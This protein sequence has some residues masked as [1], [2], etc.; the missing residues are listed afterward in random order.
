MMGGANHTPRM[1]GAQII[2]LGW[3][4]FK[5]NPYDGRGSNQ[6]PRMGGAHIILLGW[7][8][9]YP[10]RIHNLITCTYRT[11]Y[12]CH[13]PSQT[14]HL[15]ALYPTRLNTCKLFTL[16]DSTFIWK[17]TYVCMYC[18]TIPPQ[19]TPSPTINQLT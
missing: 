8:V 14:Q 16:P 10:T 2:L 11:C 15:Q 7:A 5:S 12:M 18:T 19:I 1:G 4:G 17:C 3:V 6:T 9:C 13:V